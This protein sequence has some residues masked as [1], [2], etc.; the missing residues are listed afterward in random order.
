MPEPLSKPLEACRVCG[1]RAIET[2]LDLGAQPPANSLR[3][4]VAE[5]LPAIPLV[6]CR[7]EDCGTVQLTETVSPDY[8]FRDYVWVTGTSEVARNYSV[9]FCDRILE[10]SRPGTLSVLEIA[11]ND[12][13]FLRSFRQ[14]GHKVLGIDPARNIAKV[15]EAAGIPT[16]AEFFGL[17]VARRVTAE[18][19]QADIV[20]ARNVI[21]HVADVHDVIGGMAHCLTKLGTG[22]IEFHR[23]DII[24]EG[25][26]YDSI[27]HE[28]VVY[29]SLHSIGRLLDQFELLAFDVSE[30]PIS[31]GSLV[32]YFSKERRDPSRAYRDAVERERRLG[33]D[34][35]APWCDFARRCQRH[36]AAL[37]SVVR[38]RSRN[39]N[40][41]IGYGASARSSTMLNFCGIDRRSLAAVAD[42]SPMKHGRYTPGTNI[43]I[44]A[45]KEAFDPRPDGVL[46]LAWN[47]A[48]EIIGQIR[49]ELDWHGEVIL[50][51]PDLPKTVTI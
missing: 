48:E 39:G 20:F 42:R 18:H 30:S 14:R 3:M 45:P 26:H 4:D 34:K 40:R 13:S 29:H 38:E 7:C 8:L 16:I 31:G 9:T 24:L 37:Q 49:A 36:R 28:H 2:I 19:G 6:L 35:S 51:L 17:E 10:R 27:Y 15:A 11:S 33:I 44:L 32:V 43:Q 46:L 41:L 5:M 22:A 21:P 25:L 47:F 1:S 12:G 50:P 23:A